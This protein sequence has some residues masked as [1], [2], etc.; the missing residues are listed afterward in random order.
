EA[1]PLR[2]ASLTLLHHSNG[3]QGPFLRED[4]SINT[5]DGSFGYWSAVVVFHARDPWPFLP[6][7]EAVRIERM[8]FKE[9]QLQRFYPDWTFALSLGTAERPLSGPGILR[10][11]AR[12]LADFDWSPRLANDWPASHKPYPFSGK[13]TGIYA[14]QWKRPAPGNSG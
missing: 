1:P 2:Y 3:A 4:G 8:F 6:E 11:R 5:V 13:V 7:Y 10:G 9:F 12:L 14:P